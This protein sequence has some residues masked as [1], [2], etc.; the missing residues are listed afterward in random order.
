MVEV[1]TWF[2]FDTEYSACSV[3]AK[4]DLIATGTYQVVKVDEEGG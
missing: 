4:G 1:R 2:S 3:E